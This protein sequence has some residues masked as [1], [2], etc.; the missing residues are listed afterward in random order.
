MLGFIELPTY[1]QALVVVVAVLAEAVVLYVGYGYLEE[2]FG[3]RVIN[4]I[5]NV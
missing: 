4:T 3:S 2:L 5:E 1:V